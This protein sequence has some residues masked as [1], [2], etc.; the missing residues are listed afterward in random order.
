MERK[1]RS[2]E[3]AAGASAKKPSRGPSQY[4]LR[5]LKFAIGDPTVVGTPQRAPAFDVIFFS[6][7]NKFEVEDDV[8]LENDA[9][10]LCT[11]A[12]YTLFFIKYTFIG[13]AAKKSDEDDEMD[14]DDAGESSKYETTTIA[15]KDVPQLLLPKLVKIVVAVENIF[16]YADNLN[17]EIDWIRPISRKFRAATRG[18]ISSSRSVASTIVF[19]SLEYFAEQMSTLEESVWKVNETPI[20]SEAVDLYFQTSEIVRLAK[21]HERGNGLTRFESFSGHLNETQNDVNLIK[22]AI[23]NLSKMV[24]AFIVFIVVLIDLTIR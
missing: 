21:Q 17:D 8:W 18:I 14:G 12:I 5:F 11:L 2:V 16:A 24:R 1:R 20:T 6:L 13:A 3:L 4:S 10:A 22:E 19:A 9:I 15:V 23:Y 7:L